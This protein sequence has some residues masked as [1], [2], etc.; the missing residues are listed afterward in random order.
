MADDYDEVRHPHLSQRTH[1]KKTDKWEINI[2]PC[3]R[4]DLYPEYLS[5]GFPLKYQDQ[6]E[7]TTYMSAKT[8]DH[9]KNK[10]KKFIITSGT[11]TKGIH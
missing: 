9:S 11:E 8:T 5:E 6:A 2:I 10:L 3:Q 7:L 4:H 1:E